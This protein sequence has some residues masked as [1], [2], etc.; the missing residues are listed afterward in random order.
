MWAIAGYLFTQLALRSCSFDADL[1]SP[2][3]RICTLIAK[4]QRTS[5][6]TPGTTKEIHA[7]KERKKRRS[8]VAE[9]F[10]SLP[11]SAV[12]MR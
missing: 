2:R 3:H 8:I 12:A 1:N 5:T 7:Q 11:E 10:Y 4:V 9:L 6:P